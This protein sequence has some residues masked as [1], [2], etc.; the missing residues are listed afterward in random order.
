MF[1]PLAGI[2]LETYQ[3]KGAILILA[4]LIFNCAVSTFPRPKPRVPSPESQAPSSQVS[5]DSDFLS[6]SLSFP[7]RPARA[8]S[9]ALP[10]L[11]SYVVAAEPRRRVR[12]LGTGAR[13]MFPAK[14]FPL[15]RPSDPLPRLSRSTFIAAVT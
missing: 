7:P 15:A 6:F 12:L 8:A 11:S 4:G 9:L 10:T 2:L 1:A 13:I 3:W 5:S 14:S